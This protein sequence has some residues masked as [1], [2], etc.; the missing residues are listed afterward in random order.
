VHGEWLEENAR[1]VPRTTELIKKYADA[2]VSSALFSIL[3]PG[4]TI[5]SHCGALRTIYRYHLA[6]EVP[7]EYPPSLQVRD[8]EEKGAGG[9]TRGW[10]TSDSRT[11]RPSEGR[12]A[13][14]R[15]VT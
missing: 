13:A 15:P 2:D 1:L 6:L 11:T 8:E 14:S 3:E 7:T 10:P 4:K 5:P 9:M 12:P